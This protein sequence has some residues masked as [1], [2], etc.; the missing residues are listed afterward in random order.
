MSCITTFTGLAFDPL[1]ATA[2]AIRERDIA[3]AL[4]MLCRANGHF[5]H[6]YSV[7]QHSINCMREAEARGYSTR[8]QLG[9]LLHDASEAYLSDITRPVKPLLPEYLQFEKRLQNVIFDKWITPSLTPDERAQ[10]FSVDDAMLYHEFLCLMDQRVYE[11]EPPLSSTPVFTFYPFEAVEKE[12]LRSLNRLTDTPIYVGVDWMAGKWLAAELLGKDASVKSF[13]SIEELC[14]VYNSAAS[15]VIDVPIGL[16]ETGAEMERRP[17]QAA[18]DYLKIPARKSSVF[19]APLRPV[20]YAE[21]ATEIWE[22]NNRLGGKLTPPGTGILPC[23]RQA[24]EFLRMHSDWKERLVES[25]PECAFQ[26]LNG[27]NGLVFSKHIKEGI[28]ERKEILK[29]YIVNLEELLGNFKPKQYEDL[30][31]A[32][33]LA[34]TAQVGFKSIVPISRDAEGLPMR[35][36]VADL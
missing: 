33:C 19:P 5:A 27:G 35:I 2:E 1:T 10:I 18:R 32:L 15:I 13:E 14:K 4:S 29:N 34:V 20:V 11:A 25:H 31:D 22:T 7:G 9:C 21:S 16:A 30:L 26:A 8:V 3:H 12:F 28:A 6:F 24:D 17:D 36:V 23:I